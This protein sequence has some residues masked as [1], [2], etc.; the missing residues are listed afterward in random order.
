M[1]PHT[2]GKAGIF[3]AWGHSKEKQT[4]LSPTAIAEAFDN[5]WRE[6]QGLP[7]V[8]PT[9]TASAPEPTAPQASTEQANPAPSNA[10]PV[11]S[12]AGVLPNTLSPEMQMRMQQAAVAQKQQQ[13]L[14]M[15]QMQR[16]MAMQQMSMAAAG[17]ARPPGAPPQNV[18]QMAAALAAAG[19]ALAAALNM[20]AGTSTQPGTIPASTVPSNMPATPQ[21]RPQAAVS[22]RAEAPTFTPYE[23]QQNQWAQHLQQN[24]QIAQQNAEMTQMWYSNASNEADPSTFNYQA[25]AVDRRPL[26]IVDPQSKKPI[27]TPAAPTVPSALDYL[28]VK[29]PTRKALTIV[30][31][32]SGKTVDT[33][34]AVNFKPAETKKLSIIDPSSGSSVKI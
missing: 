12:Y 3:V 7:T 8:A 21:V 24:A 6:V 18:Q 15:Q 16:Q 11:L 26:Q 25:P 27:E 29:A 30:D 1:R 32:T 31:P 23:E 14:A 19:Q 34:A 17:Q 13:Q 10:A 4:P 2:E 33:F 22:M 20:P 28:D 9:H 5:I